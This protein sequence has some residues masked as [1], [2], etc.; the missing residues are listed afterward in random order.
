MAPG[1]LIYSQEGRTLGIESKPSRS[2]LHRVADGQVGGGQRTTT[3]P[4]DGAKQQDPQ[5]TKLQEL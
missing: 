1:Q 4:S 3:T 2:A 5:Q